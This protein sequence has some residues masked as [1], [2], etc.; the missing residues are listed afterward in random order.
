MLIAP[1]ALV[2]GAARL[3][4]PYGLFSAVAM[5]PS[6]DRWENGVLWE[7]GT[8]SEL[9]AVPAPD[10]ESP[11]DIDLGLTANV[12]DAGEASSFTVYGYYHGNP[13]A[14][15]PEVAQAKALDHLLNREEARVEKALWT[16]D[17]GNTPS[18]AGTAELLEVDDP[19]TYVEGL[20]LLE[21][22]VAADYGSLG[23]IH[24]TRQM[25]S[26]GLSLQA[27][28]A[29]NGKL[30]TALGTP[31]VAGAGYDGSDPDG[32]DAPEGQSYVYVTPQLFGYRSE[33]FT[34]SGRPGDLLDRT[35]NTLY[36]IAERTYLI[37]FDTA[38]GV[39]G[40]LMKM[41]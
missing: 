38:T 12:E 40:T 20:A 30:T 22:T 14:T 3:P 36:A 25:A 32:Q 2:E 18:L 35:D 26:V 4:L 39:F 8:T 13:I 23:V 29:R 17:L 31:V 41:E 27:L 11:T 6:G 10:C 33:P 15:S 21:Q 7:P 9:G 34:S 37:G 1:A 16:G 19:Y 24:M 5:R 28:S